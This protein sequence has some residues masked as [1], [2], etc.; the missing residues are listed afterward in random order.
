MLSKLPKVKQA[1]GKHLEAPSS[2]SLW[3]E[4]KRKAFE[5]GQG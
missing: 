5:G 3:R 2:K 4:G 1:H